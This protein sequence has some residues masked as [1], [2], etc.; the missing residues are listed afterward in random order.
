MRGACGR[1]LLAAASLA[2]VWRSARTLDRVRRITPLVAT[3][4]P[5]LRPVG[6]VTV[7]VPAR[8]EAPR[9]DACVAALRAQTAPDLRIVVV[10]DG[11]TD[12]TGD[13][14]AR[15]ADAD[16]RVTAVR[17][18]GPPPGWTGKVAAMQAGLDAD[19]AA[20]AAA[21]APAPDWL[22]FVDA[23][24]VLGPALV[25]RL[26][27]TA[28][29]HGAALVSAPGTAPDGAAAAW[30]LLMPTGIVFI[31][32]HADPQGSARRAFAIGQCLLVRRDRFEAVGGW[33]ALRDRRTEDIVLAT[34]IRDAGGRTRL[35]DAG[36]LVTTSGLDPFR[37]GW[38]SFRKTLVAATGRSVPVLAAGGLAQVGLSLSGPAAALCGLRGHRTGATRPLLAGAGLLAWGLAALAHH[39]TARLMRARPGIPPLA[40]L[41]GALFGVIL[42][43]G[44]RVVLRGTAGWKGRDQ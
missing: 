22:L 19:R 27:A 14:A 10:D 6:P 7:V 29:R 33:A 2:T 25:D 34:R 28:E 36:G 42:I 5:E 35:V 37:A 13:I 43:D 16:P 20:R 12:G 41:T 3:D 17:G 39:R 32:E 1:F 8:N 15:H 40:P 38:F 30:P 44:A 23:D 26:R 11:S 9:I 31:G 24:T 18:T 21:G 4:D